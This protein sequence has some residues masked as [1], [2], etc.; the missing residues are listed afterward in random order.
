MNRREVLLSGAVLVLCS[1]RSA[2]AQ[3]EDPT[4]PSQRQ[5]AEFLVDERS[6]QAVLLGV[7]A[8]RLNLILGAFSGPSEVEVYASSM[9]SFDDMKAKAFD[10]FQKLQGSLDRNS[11]EPMEELEPALQKSVQLSFEVLSKFG[12][13]PESE[14]MR[15][16]A[17]AFWTF[18]YVLTASQTVSPQSVRDWLCGSSPFDLLCS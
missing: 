4:R 1:A 8:L 2:G 13:P 7:D 6:F 3:A 17:T 12:I 10:G 18:L 11:D 15:K 5:V 16:Q 14:L 9:P